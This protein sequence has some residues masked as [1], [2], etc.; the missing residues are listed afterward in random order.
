MGNDVHEHHFANKSLKRFV[1]LLKYEKIQID[2]EVGLVELV[3]W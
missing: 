2:V 3:D 1:F